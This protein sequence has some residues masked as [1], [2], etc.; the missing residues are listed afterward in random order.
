ME[1]NQSI[2][3]DDAPD[4]GTE[5]DVEAAEPRRPADLPETSDPDSYVE[6]PD[7]LGGTGGGSAGGAG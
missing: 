3:P 5:T 6:T 1:R 7:A 4:I 2:G